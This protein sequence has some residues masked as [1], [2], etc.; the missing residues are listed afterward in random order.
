MHNLYKTIYIE[1][2]KYGYSIEYDEDGIITVHKY[3]YAT[4]KYNLREMYCIL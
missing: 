2:L 3:S 4:Y 1:V